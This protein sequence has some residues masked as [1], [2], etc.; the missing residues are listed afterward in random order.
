MKELILIRHGEA[1]HQISNITAGWTDTKLTIL[2]KNQS[3]KTGERLKVELKSRNFKLYCSD[4]SRA[5]ESAEIIGSILKVPVI[6][7]ANLREMNNSVAINKTTEEAASLELPRTEPILDWIPYPGGESWRMMKNRIYSLMNEI[8]NMEN[9]T[10]IIVTHVNPLVVLVY[11]WLK[12]P[13]EVMVSFDF[14]NCSITE[15][16][17]NEWGERTITK[18]NDTAHLLDF[19]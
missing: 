17:I 7:N 2:G 12:L 14:D 15:L 10:I 11:W 1:D 9:N 6:T 8:N 13:E 18:L 19:E 5:Q 4:L 16:K 3:L